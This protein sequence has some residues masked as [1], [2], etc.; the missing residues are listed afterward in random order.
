MQDLTAELG[1]GFVRSYASWQIYQYTESLELLLVPSARHE[2]YAYVPSFA[3]RALQT[4][5]L[6]PIKPQQILVHAP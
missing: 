6:F 2:S 1:D 5:T 4:N 3:T